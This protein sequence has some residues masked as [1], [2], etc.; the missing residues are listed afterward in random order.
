MISTVLAHEGFDVRCANSGK[1]GL[2]L[3][4]ERAPGAIMLDWQ[5]PELGGQ[6]VLALFRS[7]AE[8]SAIPL[9][10]MSAH[11]ESIPAEELAS[12]LHIRKPFDLEDLVGCVSRA[13]S[14]PSVSAAPSA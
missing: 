10:L 5:M 12:Y 1:Q 7:H 4:S 14:R 6:D 11:L 8:L 13:V 9:I 2:A 3:A